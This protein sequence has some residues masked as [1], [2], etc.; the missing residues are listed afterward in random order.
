MLEVSDTTEADRYVLEVNDRYN[1]ILITTLQFRYN[2]DSDITRGINGSLLYFMFKAC[3]SVFG[4]F[5]RFS[6]G[7]IIVFL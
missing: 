1:A 4:R 5:P 2:A 3:M 6:F 7:G